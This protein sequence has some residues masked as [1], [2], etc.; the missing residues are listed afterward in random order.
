MAANPVP[1]R[2]LRSRFGLTFR[3]GFAAYL[4]VLPSIVFISLFVIVP[5][6][7]A[8]AYSFTTYDLLTA[9]RYAG[10]ENYLDIRGEPRFPPAIRNTVLFAIGTV[11]AGVITSLL[12]AVLI[13]R[14]IRGIYFFRAMFYMPVVSSM[15]AVSVIFLWI[16]EPQTGIISEF[17]QMLGLVPIKWMRD[18]DFALLAII[19]MSIWKNMGLNMVIYLAGLQGIPPHLYEAAEIDGAGRLSQMFRITVPLLAPTTYFVVIVYFIGALQMFV[20]VF[21][22]ACQDAQGLCGGPVDATVTIV[23]LIYIEAFAN[24]RMG[25][26]AAL[27]FI[28]FA[29]IGLITIINS[30]LLEYE[31]GY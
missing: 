24:L 28:L 1:L 11:P 12:L 25:F 20:Q 16:Y 30:K 2:A 13:N 6:L 17:M 4:F 5:I 29:V 19:L 15:V 22:M 9:P 23:L 26:A 7:G 27:S 10:F 3:G 18:P 8:L 14:G 31:I 21:I